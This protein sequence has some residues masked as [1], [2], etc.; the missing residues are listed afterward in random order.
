MI[1]KLIGIYVAMGIGAAIGAS[2]ET[3]SHAK[4]TFDEIDK[5]RIHGVLH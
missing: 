3:R 2:K 4:A 5:E 1:M